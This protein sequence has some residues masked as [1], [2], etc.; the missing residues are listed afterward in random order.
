MQSLRTSHHRRTA[1]IATTAIV[2]IAIGFF[3]VSYANNTWPFTKKNV[4]DSSSSTKA[5]STSDSNDVTPKPTTSEKPTDPTSNSVKSQSEA[6]SQE[7]TA[8][9]SNLLS[10]T[11]V[12]QSGSNVTI[13]TLIDK[14]TTEGTCSMTI[15]NLT[16]GKTYAQ[17]VNVQALASS[18]TCQGYNVP[19]S[20]LSSGK[21]KISIDYKV[22]N[23]S[24]G[25][26]SQT[27][28]INA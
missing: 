21:W 12:A 8:P 7:T 15:T 9:K 1:L 17:K 26:A 5:E 18:S 25:S 6:Q 3:A 27:E 10:I 20:T 23:T 24:Y 11:N 4:D 28:T 19:V 13:R 14:V 16:N 22:G 2:I